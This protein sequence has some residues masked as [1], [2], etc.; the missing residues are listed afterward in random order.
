MRLAA[1]LICSAAWAD[2][3]PV[4]TCPWD[5]NT[6]H[7]VPHVTPAPVNVTGHFRGDESFCAAP[8]GS[9]ARI[10]KRPD[11]FRTIQEYIDWHTPGVTLGEIMRKRMSRDEKLRD[12]VHV[13]TMDLSTQ[14]KELT[15]K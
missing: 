2:C 3:P 10:G 9:R 13:H 4:D 7:H 14:T 8:G 6:T 11:E 15:S 1:A 5:L 12:F